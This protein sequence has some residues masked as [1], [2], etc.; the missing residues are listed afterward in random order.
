MTALPVA[1]REL[2]VA[3]RQART[4]YVRLT[5]ALTVFGIVAY[6]AWHSRRLGF[7]GGGRTLFVGLTHL[8][9][10]VCVLGGASIS[11]DA[12]SREKR[13]GTLGFLFLSHL[14]GLDV[15]LGKLL[16]QATYAFYA[17]L[18]IMPMLALP[19]LEGGLQGR[20]FGF[21]MLALTNTLFFSVCLGLLVSSLLTHSRQ[22]TNVAMVVALCFWLGL[23]GL[24]ALA[25]SMS[26]PPAVAGGLAAL[27][28]ATTHAN[29]LGLRG[30]FQP[31]LALLVTHAEAW[32]F[33]FAAAGFTRRAWR[34]RPA[35][36]RR[37]RWRDGWRNFI[38]GTPARRAVRRRVLL[39]RNAFLWLSARYRWKPVGP[40]LLFLSILLLTAVAYVVVG[41]AEETVLGFGCFTLHLLL[42]FWIASEAV[43]AIATHRRDGSLELLLT[44]PLSVR[45]ILR[46]QFLHLRR[47]FGWPLV[48]TAIVT[49]L[50]AIVPRWADG[51]AAEPEL[52]TF[53]A[54]T[55]IG[56]GADAYTLVWLGTWKAIA[57]RRIRSA[58]GNAAFQV[59]LLPWLL[60]LLLAPGMRLQG[61]EGLA[62]VWLFVGLGADFIWWQWSREQLLARFRAEAERGSGT[63]RPGW[64]SRLFSQ[65]GPA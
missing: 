4:Y 9:A 38:F 35:G 15:V 2:R 41:G 14:S 65:G 32:L 11:G 23:P 45:D 21:E 25:T 51:R 60:I 6:A 39:D 12:I 29:S 46:G 22:A 57:S 63:E 8:A 43:V 48:G 62:A 18:A 31:W 30:S 19:F 36:A 3:A 44:T 40:L 26:W 5:A 53:A 27:S 28:P 33:L 61:P 1:Q 55:V 13:E 64:L 34:E 56:L 58:A 17:L 42:K 16:A 24:A 54:M 59:L 10:W 7:G 52:V 49:L 50:A 20:E 37:T 47:Q